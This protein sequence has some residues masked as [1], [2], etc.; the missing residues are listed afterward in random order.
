MASQTAVLDGDLGPLHARAAY[1]RET[2]RE[3][4]GAALLFDILGDAESDTLARDL[5]A[6][7]LDALIRS[8]SSAELVRLLSLLAD[9][10]EDY[11]RSRLHRSAAMVSLV[12]DR[13]RDEKRGR[14]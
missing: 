14:L 12:R 5:S 7:E 11:E 9:M 2:G 4:A 3:S 13:V 6:G 8:L 10:L 1:F